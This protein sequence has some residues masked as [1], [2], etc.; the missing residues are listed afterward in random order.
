MKTMIVLIGLLAIGC[1]EPVKELTPEEKRTLRDS[2][3]GEY[4]MKDEDGYTIKEVF[5]DNGMQEDYIN[6]EKQGEAKWSMSKDGELHVVHGNKM[7]MVYRI[8]PDNRIT[9]IGYIDEDRKRTDYIKRY[10]NFYTFKKIK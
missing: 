1:G 8:N 2:V 5:V 6:N 3:V 7:V 4:E 9:R 10:Q